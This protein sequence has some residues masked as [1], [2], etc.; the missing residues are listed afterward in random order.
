MALNWFNRMFRDRRPGVR[1][2]ES[3]GPHRVGHRTRLGFELLEDR[4]VPAVTVVSG[5][6]GADGNSAGATSPPNTQVAYGPS[7]ILD[8]YSTGAAPL[9][10]QRRQFRAGQ[11]RSHHDG[12]VPA[13]EP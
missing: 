8:A 4:S 12:D 6:D 7:A 10:D 9:A 1:K 13:L 11:R 2:A 3:R 5:F